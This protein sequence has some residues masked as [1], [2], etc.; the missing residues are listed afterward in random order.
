ICG[1]LLLAITAWALYQRPRLDPA[2]RLWQKAL[3][4]LARRQVNCPPWETPL[5]LARRLE[6]ERPALAPAVLEVVDAYLQARYSGIPDDL[7][8]L[9]AAIRRLP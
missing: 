4:R 6:D 1:T 9:R 2:G 8:K 5:A 7:K 3:R